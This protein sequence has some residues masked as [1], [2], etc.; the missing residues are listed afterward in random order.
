MR[1]L[2]PKRPVLVA[3]VDIGTSKTTC[4]IAE[5]KPQSNGAGSRSRTHDVE[6]LA[7]GQS[8][9]QG[10]KAG[11]V[12]DFAQIE[13]SVREALGPAEGRSL[14]VQSAVLGVSGGGLTS[15]WRSASVDVSGMV[16]DE[17]VTQVL[18]A[19]GASP[20]REGFVTLHCLPIYSVGAAQ[21][22]RDPRKMLAPN[23]GVDTLVV[24]MDGIVARDLMLALESCHVDVEAMVAG[25]YAAGLAVL[26]DHEMELGAAVIDLGAGT[27]TM[28]VFSHGHLL[29][30]TG[31]ALGG[32][33][34]TKDLARGINA[35]MADAERI[36]IHYGVLASGDT[37]SLGDDKSRFPKIVLRSPVVRIIKP[38]VEEILE[39]A[40]DRLAA[41]PFS[42]LQQ[43]TVVLT[44]GTS[45][46]PGLPELAA[47]ILACPVR[48]GAPL[49]I[50]GL[51]EEFHG[52]ACAVATGLL[53]YPQVV[54]L[55]H[56]G[57]KTNAIAAPG[58][59]YFA[60]VGAWLRQG[61]F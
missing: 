17:H 7:I 42:A 61:F 37:V 16:S 14:E 23:L 6:I 47:R 28:A 54:H 34:I 55:E 43:R 40:S 38:R 15:E 10:M 30:A 20:L 49:D 12:G 60:Q 51:T 33:H 11:A 39:M 31:F 26:S 32:H 56:L 8:D 52:P 48:I 35:N 25:P 57:R 5:L 46:L 29:Y 18:A 45:Q 50:S 3:A 41:S 19:A 13:Q 1:P 24:G 53:I 9:T 2:E 59:R 36:K 58:G 21:G 44:G 4:L 22:I 27:T